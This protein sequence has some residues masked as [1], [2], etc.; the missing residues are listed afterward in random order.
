MAKKSSDFFVRVEYEKLPLSSARCS[1]LGH[2]ISS[3][4]RGHDMPT[5]WTVHSHQGNTKAHQNGRKHQPLANQKGQPTEQQ[6]QN[7]GKKMIA[8]RIRI[9]ATERGQQDFTENWGT[10]VTWIQIRMTFRQRDGNILKQRGALQAY[11]KTAANRIEN[12]RRNRN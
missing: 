9:D 5:L 11:H 1:S 7:S 2:D 10:A 4:T 12:G 3:C 6:Q 8:W